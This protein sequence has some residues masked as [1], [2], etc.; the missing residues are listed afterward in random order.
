MMEIRTLREGRYT[1][2]R[3]ADKEDIYVLLVAE[4]TVHRL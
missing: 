3:V 2:Q 4:L 1:L